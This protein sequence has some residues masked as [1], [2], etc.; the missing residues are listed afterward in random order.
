MVELAQGDVSPMHEVGEARELDG[1]SAPY[2]PLLIA[3]GN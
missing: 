2:A 1:N 3:E